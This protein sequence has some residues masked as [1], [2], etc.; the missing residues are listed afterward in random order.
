MVSCPYNGIE[1]WFVPGKEIVVLSEN[2]RPHDIYL[3]LL[4]DE[5]SLRAIGEAARRRV[6]LDHTYRRRATDII[7]SIKEAHD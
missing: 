1:R 6:L 7:R 3:S 2:E 5:E 4:D